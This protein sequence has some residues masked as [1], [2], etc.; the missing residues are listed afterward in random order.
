MKI[1]MYVL[2]AAVAAL[3]IISLVRGIEHYMGGEG[4]NVM[5][6]GIAI[7]GMLLAVLWFKRARGM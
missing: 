2:A 3:A 5:D 6:F 1:V 4:F 7:V